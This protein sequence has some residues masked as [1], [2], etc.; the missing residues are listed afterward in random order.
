M[1]D[2]EDYRFIHNYLPKKM[3]ENRSQIKKHPEFECRFSENLVL[4]ADYHAATPTAKDVFIL[5]RPHDFQFP[6]KIFNNKAYLS[7]YDG[8]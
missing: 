6:F 7:F 1:P 4:V 5:L 8:I 3:V 2:T